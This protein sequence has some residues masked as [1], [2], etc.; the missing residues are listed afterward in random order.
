MSEQLT[1][2]TFVPWLA[3]EAQKLAQQTSDGGD[4]FPSL[5][6]VA[7]DALDWLR[8]APPDEREK[9]LQSVKH[10]LDTGT[11]GAITTPADEHEAECIATLLR[12]IARPP[13]VI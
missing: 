12:W 5:W 3:Q 7:T 11:V 4:P 1:A 6:L 2:A 9:A 8:D 10:Y 13:Q